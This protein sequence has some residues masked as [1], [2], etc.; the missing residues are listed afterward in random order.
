MEKK[1]WELRKLLEAVERELNWKPLKPIALSKV[2]RYLSGHEKP[3]HET[4]DRISLFVGFQDWESFQKAL[5][6]E[7]D[8]QEN[9]EA[10]DFTEI[11]NKNKEE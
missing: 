3:S 1:H 10:S 9:Y 7:A 11:W 4:L 8:G 6:G 5:H 2:K